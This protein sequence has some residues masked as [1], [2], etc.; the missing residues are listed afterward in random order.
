VIE[1]KAQAFT[2]ESEHRILQKVNALST[3]LD[4][5]RVDDAPRAE[6]QPV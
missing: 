1:G 3:K 5:A 6:R 2:V 4:S